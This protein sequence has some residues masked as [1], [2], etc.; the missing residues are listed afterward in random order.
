MTSRRRAANTCKYTRSK[1]SKFSTFRAIRYSMQVSP[2]SPVQATC[3]T[4]KSSTL[5][6]TNFSKM[7]LDPW[8]R[9]SI[10]AA[11]L[12]C[13][14]HTIVSK[15]KDLQ[16]LPIQWISAVWRTYTWRQTRSRQ[17][18]WMISLWAST[19]WTWP[20][21]I[22]S[23]TRWGMRACS[24]WPSAPLE[25]SSISTCS[26]MSWGRTAS[27][28]LP[29]VRT[30]PNWRSWRYSMATRERPQKQR[31]HSKGLTPCRPWDSSAE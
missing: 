16:K 21:W 25:S 19:W 22:S 26:T 9:V 14:S 29:R 2:I 30:S 7:Q 6:I 3:V 11:S 18:A 15:R 12:F 8:A 17:G 13:H 27:E 20:I 10:W 5:T 23:R 1:T 31:M 24:G 28:S 4:L